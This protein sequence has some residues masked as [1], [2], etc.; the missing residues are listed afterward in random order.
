M[1]SALNLLLPTPLLPSL[2]TGLPA[3]VIDDGTRDLAELIA[4]CSWDGVQTWILQLVKG[5]EQ[6]LH[7][8]FF[9]PPASGLRFT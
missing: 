9:F 1:W 6:G 8:L 3:A 7:M 2:V 5:W 4:S